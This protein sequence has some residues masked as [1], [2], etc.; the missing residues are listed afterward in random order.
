[1]SESALQGTKLLD[2]K[3]EKEED[4][5]FG[6]ALYR[7]TK[8]NIT[9]YTIPATVTTVADRAFKSQHKL[10]TV[11]N[12]DGVQKIGKYAFKDSL[13]FL[14]KH[15]NSEGLVVVNKKVIANLSQADVVHVDEDIEEIVECGLSGQHA[16]NLKEL[17]IYSKKIKI[18]NNAF[19]DN[20]NLKKVAFISKDATMIDRDLDI[21]VDSI[22][23]KKGSKI[24]LQGEVL[25]KLKTE[26]ENKTVTELINTNHIL[27]KENIASFLELKL[28]ILK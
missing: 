2:D 23:L 17:F 3:F 20:K 13:E 14:N 19:V 26:V 8:P 24:Y 11:N 10:K 22:N 25:S 15:K 6:N 5:I 1:M 16:L 18:S 9:E 21:D 7:V 12:L 28:Q 4:V 27:Y